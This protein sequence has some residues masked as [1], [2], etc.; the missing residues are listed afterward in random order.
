MDFYVHKIGKL[1]VQYIVMFEKWNG[2][3]HF[4]GS[5][6][7]ILS[8]S[9]IHHRRAL[10]SASDLV[11][12]V[13]LQWIFTLKKIGKPVVQCIV[14]FEKRTGYSDFS[15]S[16]KSILSM[17]GMYPARALN[18]ASDHVFDVF[19]QW[20]FTFKKIVETVVRYMIMLEDWNGFR[21]FRE[22]WN[23]FLLCEVYTLVEH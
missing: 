12:D 23:R 6:K 1:V 21:I 4:S 10:N 8:V 5:V 18:S 17:R 20:T 15:G 2:Y 11:F 3:S 16:L 9:A 14:M 7:S 13:F 19:L 22:F